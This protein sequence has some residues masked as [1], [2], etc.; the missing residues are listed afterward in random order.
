MDTICYYLLCCFNCF[1]CLLS[2]ITCYKWWKV[3]KIKNHTLSKIK[4][5]VSK[6]FGLWLLKIKAVSVLGRLSHFR[7]HFR[8]FPCKLL[9]WFNF[10]SCSQKKE[11]T[12]RKVQ[13]MNTNLCQRTFSFL[14]HWSS[15]DPSDLFCDPFEGPWLLVHWT[16]IPNSICVLPN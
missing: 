6:L 11:Y 2:G 15:Q 12:L 14:H 7:C 5:V 1:E 13:T 8:P 10:N 3:H 9:R 16:E 4:L